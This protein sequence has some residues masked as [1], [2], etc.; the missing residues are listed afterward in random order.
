MP[1]TR[2]TVRRRNRVISKGCFIVSSSSRHLETHS[3]MGATYRLKQG[4]CRALST[5]F[6]HWSCKGPSEMV[7][8]PSPRKS[9]SCS[10]MASPSQI[11]PKVGLFIANTSLMS[12][13]SWTTMYFCPIRVILKHPCFWYLGHKLRPKFC[14][15][16]RKSSGVATCMA[17]PKYG[18][19][20]GPAGIDLRSP[21]SDDTPVDCIA[22][23]N[24]RS[25][26]TKSSSP[27][28]Y[29]LSSLLN[30]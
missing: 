27:G 9:F 4:F 15:L 26:A 1:I 13:G 12:S 11:F 6:W 7:V 30:L 5:T 2:N 25:S 17:A 23:L 14:I 21:I 8:S 10:K 22:E 29:Q 18:N 20:R 3:L 24:A 16:R 28:K 19:C